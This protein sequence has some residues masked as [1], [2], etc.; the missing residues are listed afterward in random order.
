MYK[1]LGE[2]REAIK[3]SMNFFFLVKMIEKHKEANRESLQL[4]PYKN[5]GKV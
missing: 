2:K 3:Q 5:E 1:I 4:S